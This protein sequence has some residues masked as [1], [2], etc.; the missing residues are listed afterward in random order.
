MVRLIKAYVLFSFVL[1]LLL[2]ETAYSTEQVSVKF[3]YW[4]PRTDLEY[5]D[6]CETWLILRDNFL[7]KDYRMTMI[8]ADY[9]GRVLIEWKE[10]YNGSYVDGRYITTVNM[11]GELSSDAMQAHMLYNVTQPNSLVIIGRDGNFT[12]IE[13]DFNETY[14]R[15]VIDAY[16]AELEPQIG[17]SFD[18]S[19]SGGVVGFC[20]VVVP[21]ALIDEPY[22]VLI[23]GTEVDVI[24]LDISNSTHGYLY[25]TYN[26]STE[27]VVI[28]PEFPSALILP[29]FIIVT[30]T[31]VILLKHKYPRK[32]THALQ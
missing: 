23:N 31:M 11:D 13:G 29:L 8:Q 5:C 3:L 12:L 22:T 25:F 18:V 30:L 28:T 15:E 7:E 27:H 26:L 6:I 4:D 2:I 10:Y 21:R 32:S 17:V 14:I 16:L 24:L 20:R 19:G 9:A 1:F